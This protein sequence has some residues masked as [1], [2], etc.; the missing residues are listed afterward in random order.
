MSKN[1]NNNTNN[2][3]NSINLQIASL[4]SNLLTNYPTNTAIASLLASTVQSQTTLR[5]SAI[6]TSLA[7]ANLFTNTSLSNYSSTILTNTAIS[8][9]INLNNTSNIAYTNSKIITEISRADLA[10][11]NAIVANNLLYT[12]STN[13]GVG[14]QFNSISI[15][16]NVRLFNGFSTATGN[17][18][19]CSS[20]SC[21]YGYNSGL[22][23]T[24]ANSSC[25]FFG[26][27]SGITVASSFTNSTAIGN[28]SIINQSNQIMLGDVSTSSYCANIITPNLTSTI[29][30]AN[31][32]IISIE[33]RN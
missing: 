15:G 27:M 6:S 30:N 21:A 10:L 14:S 8:N 5:D 33:S 31:L 11:S 1:F 22:G 24:L 23:C 3:D 16:P 18:A 7:S 9:A 26:S 17:N 32:Q 20:Y 25:N 2:N 4:N 12:P 28:G 19:T 29:H 13:I